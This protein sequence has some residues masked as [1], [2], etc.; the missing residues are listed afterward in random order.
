[1][2]VQHLVPILER[3]KL[4]NS[5]KALDHLPE[6]IQLHKRLLRALICCWGGGIG[7]VKATTRREVAPKQTARDLS[8][9]STSEQL[10]PERGEGA[11]EDMVVIAREESGS[12]EDHDDDSFRLLDGYDDAAEFPEL[13]VDARCS[14]LKLPFL[15]TAEE[16][17][18]TGER[19]ERV[20]HA[21]V[22][23]WL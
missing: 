19:V 1:M 10:A 23:Q 3:R 7:V 12:E 9:T 11:E 5:I 8:A 14:I 13:R 20:F 4:M 22:R 15:A 2:C 18:F 6:V 17:S 21:F 16:L